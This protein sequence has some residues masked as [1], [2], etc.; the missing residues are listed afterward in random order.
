MRRSSKTL[1][2]I[3]GLLLAAF[4][5]APVTVEDALA[6][7][8]GRWQGE[9]QYR[10]YQSD[11]WQGLPVT[12]EIGVQP[13]HA[14]ILRT[15]SYDDGPRTGIVTI[16]TATL[17]DAT[18]NEARYAILRRGRAIDTGAATIERFAPGADAAHW[19]LTTI[20][21]R[22]DGNDRAQVRETTVRDGDE[23]VTT[24]S[25]N[26]DA[27]GTDRWLPRNRTVLKRVAS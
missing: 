7:T 23:M 17:F 25:V 3:A 12:I 6:G 10:D 9:L 13:D 2:P 22:M 16:T 8:A 19:T 14:T 20:E 1:L 18:A 11:S 27:D 21:H 24:K 26:P 5:P 15:A 4:A